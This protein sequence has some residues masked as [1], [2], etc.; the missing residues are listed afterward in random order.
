[1]LPPPPDLLAAYCQRHHIRRLSLLGSRS[2][3]SARTDSDLDLLVEF[4]VDQEPGLIGLAGMG[5]ELADLLGGPRVDLP[6]PEDLSR[7]FRADVLKQAEVW[8]EA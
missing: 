6:T 2:K 3:G 7:Y 1:M 8:Y 5:L 4:E